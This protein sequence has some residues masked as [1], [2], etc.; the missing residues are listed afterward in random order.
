VAIGFAIMIETLNQVASANR[1]KR[2]RHRP[3]R[4]R[5][6]DAVLRLL[7]GRE[8]DSDYDDYDRGLEAEPALAGASAGA[9][10]AEAD[11][12]AAFQPSERAMIKGVLDLAE[13]QVTEIMT[14]R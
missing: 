6:A 7:G 9:G 4:E 3:L 11:L 2:D 14:P 10:S 5:T 8:E 12:E 1:R 13:R